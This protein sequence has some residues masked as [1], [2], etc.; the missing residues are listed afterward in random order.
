M[1]IIS[2]PGPKDSIPK[3]NFVK[4]RIL[5][6]GSDLP[7]AGAYVWLCTNPL[8]SLSSCDGQLSQI[9]DSN[10][11]CSFDMQYW[12]QAAATKDGYWSN[13]QCL[14]TNYAD[15]FVIRL[16]PATHITVHLKE[17]PM[18]KGA[19]HEAVFFRSGIWGRISDSTTVPFD[20][21][22]EWSGTGGGVIYLR[23]YIDTT[24]Q[25]EAYGNAFN[26][27]KVND[28][29]EEGWEHTGSEYY[30]EYKYIPNISNYVLDIT[31]P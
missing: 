17:T 19:G 6:Y 28:L 9:T 18:N 16:I 12:S 8:D 14:V 29:S 13:N 10:G 31:Y 26:I 7:V 21:C 11:V 23:A 27:L 3:S 1:P 5:E 20:H 30:F 22:G 15:S 2:S 25:L 24:F 4:G